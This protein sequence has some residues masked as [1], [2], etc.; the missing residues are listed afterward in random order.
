MRNAAIIH[1]HPKSRRRIYIFSDTWTGET[2]FTYPFPVKTPP[3]FYSN[4]AIKLFTFC[5]GDIL[6]FLCVEFNGYYEWNMDPDNSSEQ[7]WMECLDIFALFLF[8]ITCFV[9]AKILGQT[10]IIFFFLW[11]SSTGCPPCFLGGH[12]N[13]LSTDLSLLLPHFKNS[14]IVEVWKYEKI[15]FLSNFLLG[16]QVP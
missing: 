10:L 8:C 7:F 16:I 6:E 4:F 2:Y 13:K 11:W 1:L 15:I 3:H 14:F 9:L 5:I 12:G